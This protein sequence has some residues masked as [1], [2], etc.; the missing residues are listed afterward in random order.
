MKHS[1]WHRQRQEDY[2]FSIECVIPNILQIPLRSYI[3]LGTYNDILDNYVCVIKMELLGNCFL[4]QH[5][6]LF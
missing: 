5:K 3:R 2:K 1:F 4:N 6:I